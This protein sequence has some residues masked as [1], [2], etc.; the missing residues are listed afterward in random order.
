MD[1]RFDETVSKLDKQVFAK[2]YNFLYN[3]V[4][5]QEKKAIKDR[6][7][8]EKSEAKRQELQR[9]MQ[10]IE[11]QMNEQRQLSKKEQI[12]KEVKV[13]TGA[14]SSCTVARPARSQLHRGLAAVVQWHRFT[15]WVGPGLAQTLYRR[16]EQS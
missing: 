2:R 1:P 13:G 5:P 7:A 11:S 8:K 9:S 3:E 16:R 14:G 4:L 12:Q 6:L 15:S 10:R